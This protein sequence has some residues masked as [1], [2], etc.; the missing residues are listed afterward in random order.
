MKKAYRSQDNK[1]YWDKRWLEI[2]IDADN[3]Q[4]LSIYPI[5]YAEMVMQNRENTSTLEL[6]CGLGRILKHYHYQGYDITGIE[7]SQIAVEK[8]KTEDRTLKITVSDAKRLPFGD[9]T[10]NTLLAF[11]FYHNIETDMIAALKESVR[12]LKP[13]GTFCISVRTIR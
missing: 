13:G 6:G 8:V 9:H 4:D 11:G 3:F 5:R 7:R 10:F 2:E 12:C 1:S